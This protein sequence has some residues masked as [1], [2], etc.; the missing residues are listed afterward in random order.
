LH[1]RFQIG[2]DLGVDLG[3]AGLLPLGLLG[4]AP[5][6]LGNEVGAQAGDRLALPGRLDLGIVAVAAGSAGGGGGGTAGGDPFP[7]AA[8]VA[9]A[10]AGDGMVHGGAH[11]D[12]V[13]A[14]HL[15]AVE[16]AGQALLGQGLGAGLGLARHR[17][18]PL[19]VDD[20]QDEGQG[21]GA[22]RVDRRVGIG[23]GTA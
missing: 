3:G 21:V 20:A 13:V 2:I 9:I 8:A 4:L 6:A 22:G 12:D 5:G 18:R 14:V 7:R 17:D 23:L 16:A 1:L 15:H 10:G 11:G 19:V